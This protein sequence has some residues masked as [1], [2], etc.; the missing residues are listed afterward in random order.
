MSEVFTIILISTWFHVLKK[1][2][3]VKSFIFIVSEYHRCSVYRL[4]G[5]AWM[6][7]ES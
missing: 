5:N 7:Y 2:F 4:A 6:A 3:A 1:L